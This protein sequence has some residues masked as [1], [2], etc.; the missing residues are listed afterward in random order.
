MTRHELIAG[1]RRMDEYERRI[2]VILLA[3]MF[4]VLL[5]WAGLTDDIPK[6][7]KKGQLWSTCVFVVAESGVAGVVVWKLLRG[8]RRYGLLCPHCRAKLI[9]SLGQVAVATG[10]CGVCGTKVTND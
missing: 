4:A 9:R 6:T 7:D 8:P 5:V 1:K 3:L 10:V 2:N